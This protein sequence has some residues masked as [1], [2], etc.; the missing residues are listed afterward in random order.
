[1]PSKHGPSNRG[2]LI[3]L[4]DADFEQLHALAEIEKCGNAEMV[5]RLIAAWGDYFR[6]AA[7]PV[8]ETVV[9]RQSMGRK[10]HALAK[11]KIEKQSEA[12]TRAIARTARPSFWD[13]RGK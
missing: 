3:R 2:R 1:M 12:A 9:T 13:S 6:K 10:D 7:L 8:R 5:R 11:S 4:P